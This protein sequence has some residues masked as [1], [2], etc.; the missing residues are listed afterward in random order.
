M[1]NKCEVIATQLRDDV[2]ITLHV[3]LCTLH[4]VH[5]PPSETLHSRTFTLSTIPERI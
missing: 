1:P 2:R 5:R 3:T 4:N